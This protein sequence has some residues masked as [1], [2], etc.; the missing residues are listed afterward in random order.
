MFA[1]MPHRHNMGFT[2][3]ELM[4]VLTIVGVILALSGPSM[5][6]LMQKNRLQTAADNFYGTLVLAR[7]EAIKRNQPVVICK[8]SNGTACVTS[9]NWEQGWLSFT[10]Q[11]ADAVLDVGEPILRVYEGLQNGDTLRVTGRVSKMEIPC[12]SPAAIL[13]IC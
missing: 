13:T 3:I 8:S 2:L 4:I 7:S 12:E 6:Q 1:G 5:V 9:G 11:D 10:D